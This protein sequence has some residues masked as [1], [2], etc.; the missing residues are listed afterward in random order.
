M[1]KIKIEEYE[2]DFRQ[3]CAKNLVTVHRFS[4]VRCNEE[5]GV[6]IT[7]CAVEQEGFV[8]D[9]QKYPN[10][11]LRSNADLH[12]WFDLVVQLVG[13]FT[14]V[15]R[16][17]SAT[18]DHT[19]DVKCVPNGVR[20]ILCQLEVFGMISNVC[21]MN[22]LSKYDGLVHLTLSC[23]IYDPVTKLS[24]ELEM[25]V[26]DSDEDAAFNHLWARVK[27]MVVFRRL[28]DSAASRQELKSFNG[29]K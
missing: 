3:Y 13:S 4:Y 15:V 23:S 22:D 12:A 7:A 24:T 19:A 1:F 14:Y 28:D 27:E 11:V 9:L 17:L 2:A 29:T 10:H 6:E 25:D 8:A 21:L 16:Q 5:T 20:Y 26:T 18:H